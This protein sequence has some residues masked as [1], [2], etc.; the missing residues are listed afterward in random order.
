M[1][2][3][4]SNGKQ[5]KE[6]ESLSQSFLKKKTEEPELPTRRP[7][8]VVEAT[9]EFGLT[10]SQVRA[11]EMAGWVNTPVD[12]PSKT[13][14]QIVLDNTFT[15]FNL[16]FF[17]LAL[18]VIA[19][20][21]W[22]NL[23]FMGVIIVNTL[24]G[25]YQELKAKET[26]SE[27]SI[28]AAPKAQ[29]I[30][31]GKKLEMD[32]ARL[33]RDDVVE[34]SAGNQIYADAVVIQGS[35]HA[36]EALITGESDEILKNVGDKLM[37]GSFIINGTCRARLTEVGADSFAAKLTL[38]AKKAKPSRQSEMMR[39]LT[40]LIKWIGIFVIPLAVIM[41]I[42]EYTWL[43]RDVAT[44]VTS[45]VGSIIGMI[46]E[47]LYLLTSIALMAGVIRLAQ[48]KTLVHDMDCIETLARVDVLC[49][50]KTGTI[51]EN[52]MIVENTV[53]LE[54]EY[55]TEYVEQL[56]SNYTFAM[57]ADNDTMVAL[58][59]Y[60]T[61]QTSRKATRIMP[62][63]SKKKYGGATFT[64]GKTYLLGAPEIIQS[65]FCEKRY[66]EPV[67]RYSSLGCRVLMLAEYEG[68]LDDETLTGKV[69]P[70]SLILLSNKI[71]D[72]APDTFAYFEKQGVTVKV[73]SGDNPA[74]VAE[75]AGRAGIPNSHQ[76]VDART[77][78][79][80]EEIHDA[81][82]RFT[83]FGR[84]TP[85]QKKQLVLALK[86][87]GHTVAMTGDGVNDVLALKEA[88]CSI[89]MASGSDVASQASH[90]VL[91]D[92]N[93]A[94]MPSVV[95]EGRRVINNIELSASLYLWKNIFTFC[96]ALITLIFTLPYPYS[97]AQMALVNGLTIGFPSFVLALEPNENL[98]SGRFLRNVIHRALPTAMTDLVL[99]LGI[100]LFYL[101][102]DINDGLL[103]TICT[104]VMGIVGLMMVF[105]TSQ[106]FNTI[107]K[108]MFGGVTVVY[109]FCYFVI[110]KWFTLTPLNFK[111]ALILI[112]FALFSWP[113]FSV[114][115]KWNMQIKE[116]NQKRRDEKVSRKQ[117]KT[118]VDSSEENPGRSQTTMKGTEPDS[119]ETAEPF[120]KDNVETQPIT[121]GIVKPSDVYPEKIP[122][123]SEI[124][125]SEDEWIKDN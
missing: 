27:L 53:P 79:T 51:T 124:P 95:A 18:A 119:L 97:P 75:V 4:T 2:Y 73:I 103:S 5:R 68:T 34:F 20:Q 16:I 45:T 82:D 62:F 37:S 92:S 110:P 11:R 120:I 24:I 58:K 105:R 49:V 56:M 23:T 6:V 80:E 3:N 47:G 85:D 123:R 88:D 31:E 81:A 107:R 30:R 38:E 39:S 70:I 102:F 10:A 50:D 94:S 108:V 91:L 111:G 104:G 67:D 72:E 83:V 69:I 21:Q 65:G 100:M 15:Y 114:F 106:P 13:T 36:N 90:I 98:I 66:D 125:V 77:L 101:A 78:T 28:L 93:F 8:E 48:R 96:L 118:V 29:V 117:G 63:T 33:V 115:N 1:C 26:L 84:V 40:N 44:A 116:L 74:T 54:D 25:I 17:I 112:V 41:F 60:Y 19:V 46:P 9:P 121:T 42:K 89:A 12:P 59:K 86:D 109:A 7:V 43:G 22:L 52:K 55:S 14:K 99:V 61:G 64:D 122:A 35:V 57:Q 32:T 76:Y 87:H 71:R 113:L